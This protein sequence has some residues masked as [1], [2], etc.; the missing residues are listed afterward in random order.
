M[1]APSKVL[2]D[3]DWESALS[4]VGDTFNHGASYSSRHKEAVRE[5]R[6]DR[7][8]LRAE[9]DAMRAERAEHL[10]LIA[11]L[12]EA[13]DACWEPTCDHKEREALVAR[14]RALAAK[15]VGNG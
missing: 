7:A 3:S 6:E 11:D 14:A 10:S 13:L 2:D 8:A 12:A 5:L 1:T 4:Y 9:L 15:G